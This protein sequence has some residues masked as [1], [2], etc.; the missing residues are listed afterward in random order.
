MSGSERA[1]V[2]FNGRLIEYTVVRSA[3]R[4]KTIEI[5]LDPERGVLV[6]SPARTTRK[7]ISELVQKRAGWILNHATEAILDPT[8]RRF[9]D[10]ETLFYL[11][12]QVPIVTD[13]ALDGRIS[14]SLEGGAFH[15]SAPSDMS[16]EDR[17][18]AVREVVERWYR[19]E[20]ARLLPE[21]VLRWQGKVSRK[22]PTQ[23]LIRSQRRRW[24][25]CSSDGSIRLNWRIVMA[26]A[27]LIDYVVVH[28]LAHLDVMDHSPRY[29][30][31]VESAMPDYRLRRKRLNDVGAHFWL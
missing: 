26:E 3:R 20:A 1:S 24:G 19:R 29:W 15:I 22:K 21:I 11:G 12:E 27:A 6:R 16:E 5:T 17:A 8:P 2:E 31:K 14:L 4:K 13:T 10:G 25:S 23:V 7:D 30:Q 9:T 18:A 28:E